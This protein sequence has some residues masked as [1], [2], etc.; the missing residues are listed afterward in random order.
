MQLL[1]VIYLKCS[2]AVQLTFIED[3]DIVIKLIRENKQTIFAEGKMAYRIVFHNLH[4]FKK[5]LHEKQPD[6]PECEILKLE[7]VKKRNIRYFQNDSKGRSKVQMKG[8]ICKVHRSIKPEDTVVKLDQSKKFISFI[9]FL[10]R[11]KFKILN[12]EDFA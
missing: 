3:I 8:Q 10:I 9:C 7:S 4:Q 2:Q 11:F 1:V 6:E 12:I 5:C